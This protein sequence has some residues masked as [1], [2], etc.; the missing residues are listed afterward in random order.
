MSFLSATIPAAGASVDAG[1]A[2]TTA[3]ADLRFLVVEDHGFQRWALGNTLAA[4]GATEVQSAPDGRAALEIMDALDGALDVIVTDLDMPGMDGLEFLRHIGQRGTPV[5]VILAS[6]LDPSLLVTVEAMAKEYGVAL[7]ANVGKPVTA[8]KLEAALA[9]FRPR[10]KSDA[11]REMHVFQEREIREGMGKGQFEAFFQ[12]R[13]RLYD[14]TVAGAQALVRWRHPVK[15]VIAPDSFIGLADSA[16]L[17]ESLT[18]AIAAQA[19]RAW[20]VWRAQGLPGGLALGLSP[21]VVRGPD[22]AERLIEVMR[23]EHIEPLQVI[24]GV[25]ESAC[26]VPGAL[27]NL[28]RLRMHG[29]GLSIDD[30]GSG[31]SPSESLARVALTE[32][33][34]DR[35]LV[36]QACLQV[37]QRARLAAVLDTARKLRIRAVA[38]G[39]ETEAEWEL[40]RALGCDQAQGG[41]IAKPMDQASYVE[42]LRHPQRAA[43]PPSGVHVQAAVD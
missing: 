31:D 24:V 22:F 11:P 4:M 13:V 10:R 3:I 19:A 38:A 17:A 39:V 26:V 21:A 2:P 32:V 34:I 25:N 28:A 37:E 14:G 29:F 43:L 35:S 7:L 23:A 41:L 8:R 33:K 5:S 1:A 27:E 30:Y 42:W 20:N 9:G 12:P 18:L 16:G 15:G 6:G 40:L 36:R